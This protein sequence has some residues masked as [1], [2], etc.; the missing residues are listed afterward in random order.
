MTVALTSGVRPLNTRPG[1]SGRSP[2]GG[3]RAAAHAS[4]G[5]DTVNMDGVS[6][7]V[8]LAALPRPP[9]PA[10][11]RPASGVPLG[12]RSSASPSS[13]TRPYSAR[14]DLHGSPKGAAAA[15]A[16]SKAGASAT[17]AGAPAAAVAGAANP[18]EEEGGKS[19]GGGAQSWRG[20]AFRAAGFQ[21][22]SKEGRV[23]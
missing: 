14:P 20:T 6:L 5:I 3:A 8:N 22:G 7:S 4:G 1:S 15:A 2:R 23:S 9:A 21:V 13:P 19:R 11:A 10:S 17:T 18:K 12:R 16:V